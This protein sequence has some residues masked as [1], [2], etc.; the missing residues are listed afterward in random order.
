VTDNV[1]DEPHI[2]AC[3]ESC[4]AELSILVKQREMKLPTVWHMC[5][6]LDQDNEACNY[7]LVDHDNQKIFWAEEVEATEIGLPE[8]ASPLQLGK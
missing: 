5:L 2:R 1:I 3:L 6:S 7:Y 4:A 8:A